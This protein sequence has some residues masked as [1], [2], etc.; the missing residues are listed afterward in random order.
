MGIKPTFTENLPLSVL[1]LLT[2]QNAKTH[3]KRPLLRNRK[4]LPKTCALSVF[5]L[6][7]FKIFKIYVKDPISGNETTF[8]ET[9]CFITFKHSKHLTLEKKIW[10]ILYIGKQNFM[11]KFF[12]CVLSLLRTETLKCVETTHY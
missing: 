4:T 2:Y 9:C 1:K 12:L 5:Q 11:T 7:I 6:V 8:P 10:K 3:T